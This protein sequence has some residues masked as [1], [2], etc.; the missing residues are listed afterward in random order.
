MAAVSEP[1]PDLSDRMTKSC[2]SGAAALPIISATFEIRNQRV[3]NT[4][5]QNGPPARTHLSRKLIV[6]DG[7]EDAGSKRRAVQAHAGNVVG[8]AHPPRLH[9]EPPYQ[10]IGDGDS[11]RVQIPVVAQPATRLAEVPEQKLCGGGG[12]PGRAYERQAARAETLG[13]GRDDAGILTN[14]DCAAG[15]FSEGPS[16]HCAKLANRQMAWLA[17]VRHQIQKLTYER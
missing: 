5:F 10:Q 16:V 8:G 12:L 11:R 17:R 3:Q 2:C 14:I 4:L 6:P 13:R 15:P 7:V 9:R 1:S